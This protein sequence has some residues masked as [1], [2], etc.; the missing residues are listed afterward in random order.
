MSDPKLTDV[1]LIG[2]DARLSRVIRAAHP[3][4]SYTT[5]RFVTHPGSSNALYVDLVNPFGF[6][7]PE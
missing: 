4:I 5:R 2:G 6:E 3:E 7:I 1:L